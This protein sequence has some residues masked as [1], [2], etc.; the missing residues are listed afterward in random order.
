MNAE[1]NAKRDDDDNRQTFFFWEIHESLIDRLSLLALEA[2]RLGD[3]DAAPEQSPYRALLQTG[4]RNDQQPWQQL[5]ALPEDQS[6]IAE[7]HAV[8]QP[9]TEDEKQHRLRIGQSR[10]ADMPD[11][12]NQS[13]KKQP[14]PD[15]QFRRG[16]QHSQTGSAQLPGE[17]RQ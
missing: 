13:D 8:E 5:R 11:A 15:S 4:D 12:R 6:H 7:H 1:E 3:S 9:Q 17:R 14:P 10:F 2:H 16:Q